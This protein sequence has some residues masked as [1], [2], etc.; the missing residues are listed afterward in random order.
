MT[1]RH[2]AARGA[3]EGAV[4]LATQASLTALPLQAPLQYIASTS[5]YGAAGRRPFT[6]TG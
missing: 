1:P 6:R 5:W 4:R 2:D 3:V